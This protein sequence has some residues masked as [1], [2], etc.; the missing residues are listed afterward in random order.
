MDIRKLKC[1][2]V[3]GEKRSMSKAARET[4]YS[5]Q[6]FSKLIASMESELG[7]ALLDRSSEGVSFTDDGRRCLKHAVAILGEWEAF[8]RSLEAKGDEMR[9]LQEHPARIL[10]TPLCRQVL[11]DPLSEKV[12]LAIDM[13]FEIDTQKA[14]GDLPNSDPGWIA[15]LD[16]PRSLF[17]LDELRQHFEIDIVK[18]DR[19]IAVMS[20]TSQFDVPVSRYIDSLPKPMLLSMPLGIY[21]DETI[22]SSLEVTF[23][24]FSMRNVVVRSGNVGSLVEGMSAGRYCMIAPEGLWQVCMKDR[25]LDRSNFRIAHLDSD[26]NIDYAFVRPISVETTEDGARYGRLLADLMRQM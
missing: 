19:M 6:G 8:E 18:T 16:L 25:T 4:N 1:L 21:E 14:L 24:R 3:L 7:C 2:T 26:F 12:N 23:P 17:N 11:L 10:I 22:H 20:S 9:F 15:L 13:C 5:V